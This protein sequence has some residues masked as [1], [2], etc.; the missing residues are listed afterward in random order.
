MVEWRATQPCPDLNAGSVILGDKTVPILVLGCEAG[1]RPAIL[2]CAGRRHRLTPVA[3]RAILQNDTVD[4]AGAI[5]RAR[6]GTHD[7]RIAV[8]GRN[9]RTPCKG[10]AAQKGEGEDA[11]YS[12]DHAASPS[13]GQRR[14]PIGS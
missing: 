6:F 13:A 11:E 1:H 12:G 2:L 5:G 9:E 8:G 14:R 3:W 7:V 10:A 4:C